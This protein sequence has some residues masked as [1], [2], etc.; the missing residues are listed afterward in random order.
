MCVC[1]WFLSRSVGPKEC[2]QWRELY[3]GKRLWFEEILHYL[4]ALKCWGEIVNYNTMGVRP[5]SSSPRTV[6]QCPTPGSPSATRR[7]PCPCGRPRRDS[8]WATA[9]SSSCPPCCGGR[10]TPLHPLLRTQAEW[11]ASPTRCHA[12]GPHTRREIS[13]APA[14]SSVARRRA[15]KNTRGTVSS[16]NHFFL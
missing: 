3:W 10:G 6:P 11:S 15:W 8:A 14:A 1:V 4:W 9:A 5:C 16:L 7:A 2:S 13:P 12:T